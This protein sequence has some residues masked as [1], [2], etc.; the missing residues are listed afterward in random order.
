[1]PAG[2]GSRCCT[3]R[4]PS[5]NQLV[6]PL[7]DPMLRCHTNMRMAMFLVP[8]FRGVQ[9]HTMLTRVII[10][11]K[12]S[13]SLHRCCTYPPGPHFCSQHL[14]S[15]SIPLLDTSDNFVRFKQSFH[16]TLFQKG[17]R[18]RVLNSAPGAIALKQ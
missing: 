16:F 14:S 3:F 7:Y 13:D 8:L 9:P 6:F 18:C 2:G 12:P 11:L 4:R 1:M 17:L 5:G 15:I 10:R